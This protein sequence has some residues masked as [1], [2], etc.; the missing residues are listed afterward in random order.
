MKTIKNQSVNVP[1]RYNGDLLDTSYALNIDYLILNLSGNPVTDTQNGLTI[2][3]ADYGTKVFEKRAKLTYQG[4]AFA[5]MTFKPRS[6]VIDENL[7]QMQLENHLFYTSTPSQLRQKVS[8]VIDILG[9]DFSGINRL[10]IALDFSQ[11][12]HDIPNLLR[13]VFNGEFL[14]SG[15]E[16]DVNVYT[17]TK[18]G[19]IEFTGV[20]I[21]K[22]SSSR[23]CRIYNKSRE[24][25]TGSLKPYI[26]T[27]WDALGLSGE[28]WRYEY[29]LS[30]KYLSEQD[31]LSLDVL[32]SK[33]FIFNLLEKARA[34]HF[35][36]KENT[37]KSEVNK[38]RTHQ[39]IDFEKVGRAIGLITGIIG[40]IK[41][42]IKETFIGQ[43]RMVK[44]LLRS[45]FSSN[46]DIR[47]LLPIRRILDDF[48]LLEWYNSKFSLYVAEFRDKEKIKLIDLYRYELDF[49]LEC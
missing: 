45:Y 36:V 15:R 46:H 13:G 10:D 48:D 29:Q 37:G 2:D 17:K 4:E 18:K 5:T 26:T 32:F 43:Q 6:T 1:D 41:R 3:V 14:I 11:E 19:L 7:V 25:Q 12:Q 8:E 34:N 47:F 22:R 42:T 16:K 38:E 49:N 20:Q 30:N 9:L 33:N 31:N 27:H 40:K 35:E 44:G 39:F 21:G 23:F 24:L 28:I